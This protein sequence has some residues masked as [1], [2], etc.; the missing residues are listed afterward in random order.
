MA[1]DRTRMEYS[2]LRACRTVAG[3][4]EMPSQ[5]KRTVGGSDSASAAE[6]R[7]VEMSCSGNFPRSW[8]RCIASSLGGDSLRMELPNGLAM[9]N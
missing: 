1:A 6:N 3:D 9:V 4:L 7:Y 2:C 5:T 8:R